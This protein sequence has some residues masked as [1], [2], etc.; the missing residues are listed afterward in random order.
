MLKIVNAGPNKTCMDQS[1]IN[2]TLLKECIYFLVEPICHIPNNSFEMGIFSKRMKIAKVI[3]IVKSIHLQIIDQFLYYHNFKKYLKKLLNNRLDKFLDMNDILYNSQY[4]FRN[5]SKTCHALIDLDEQLTKSI[6]D[7][8]C[9]VGVFFFLQKFVPTIDHSLSL[10][11]LSR[12][13]IR[14]I[15][16]LWLSSYLKERTQYVI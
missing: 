1:D 13:G 7:K 5:N 3:P 15:A 14:G 11:K 16:N 2:F 12:Y 6:D 8:L 9:R 10:Q 4:G